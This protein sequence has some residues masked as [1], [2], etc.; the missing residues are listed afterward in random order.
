MFP[1][2][3][4][5]SFHG[6][7]EE[8]AFLGRVW[9]LTNMPSVDRREPNMEADLRR[10][11]GWG[12]YDDSQV[13]YSLLNITKCPDE[14]FGKFLAECLHPLVRTDAAGVAELTTPSS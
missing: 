10:H 5:D 12:D 7:M 6:R 4:D 11:L 3:A 1:F 13:L 14:Q 2:L 9:D 8:V